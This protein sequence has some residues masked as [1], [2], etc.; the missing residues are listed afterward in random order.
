MYIKNFKNATYISKIGEGSQALVNKYQLNN[1]YVAVKNYFATDTGDIDSGA[2]KEVVFLKQLVNCNEFN[3]VIDVDFIMNNNDM[4]LRIMT[5]YYSYD[6]EYFIK[7]TPNDI[8]L[9]NFDHV[10]TTLLKALYTLHYRSIIHC[11]I[12]PANILMDNNFNVFLADFGLSMVLPCDETKRQLPLRFVGSLLWNSPE[13]LTGNEYYTDQI[14]VWSLGITML[15]Y[16]IKDTITE[17]NMTFLN[18]YGNETS[19]LYQIFTQCKPIINIDNDNYMLV[20]SNQLHAHLD[21]VKILNDYQVV[22]DNQVINLLTTM[23]QINP[24]DR[25]KI[26]KF[27][28]DVCPLVFDILP[29]GELHTDNNINDYYIALLQMIRA[30]DSFALNTGTCLM[31]IDVFERY[32]VHRYLPALKIYKIVAATCLLLMAK[33]NEGINLDIEEMLDYYEHIFNGT[34]LKQ[35]EMI[36]L[37]K[38]NYVLTSCELDDY[39]SY[40]NTR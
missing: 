27:D 4:I 7:N 6:L 14:D 21:I 1:G 17:P 34:S 19:I 23:L 32:I 31:A 37:K 9:K 8:R 16:I 26:T 20:K 40:F 13:L 39:L 22:V 3:Q 29:R 18:Q 2:V 25:L 33:I 28:Y 30:S 11:D 35:M 38:M 10:M 24:Y 36:V 5:P 15:E 12:K